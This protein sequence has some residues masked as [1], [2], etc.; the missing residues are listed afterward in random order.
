MGG[1]RGWEEEEG[2]EESGGWGRV[3]PVLQQPATGRFFLS[4][5]IFQ[6]VWNSLPGPPPV[7]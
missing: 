7:A 6:N 4:S 1:G 2:G 5:N 3:S